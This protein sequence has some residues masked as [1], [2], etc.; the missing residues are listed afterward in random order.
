[1]ALS[2]EDPRYCK[3]LGFVEGGDK[4]ELEETTGLPI[5]SKDVVILDVT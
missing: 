5:Y 4:S 2:V 1:M 3:G